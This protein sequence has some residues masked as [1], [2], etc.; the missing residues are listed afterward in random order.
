CL[1]GYL[2][3]TPMKH[4]EFF[5]C[6]IFYNLSFK[7]IVIKLEIELPFNNEVRQFKNFDWIITNQSFD[8]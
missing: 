6:T 8:L 3:F 1:C 2:Q 5:C 4:Y 7:K